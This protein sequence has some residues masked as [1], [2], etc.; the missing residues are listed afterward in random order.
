MMNEVM[1]NTQ[2]AETN[3]QWKAIS[4]HFSNYEVSNLGNVRKLVKGEYRP[5]KTK[6]VKQY[7]KMTPAFY[8]IQC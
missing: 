3:E 2:K 1:M 5:V 8:A 7:G 6:L 4:K